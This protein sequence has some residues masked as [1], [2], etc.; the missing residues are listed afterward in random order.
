[1]TNYPIYTLESAPEASHSAL[2]QLNAE[3]G[4]LP[5]LAAC[6]ADSP[7]MISGFTALR[8]AYALSTLSPLERE[9][10]LLAAAQ[11]YANVYGVAVHSTMASRMGASSEVVEAVRSGVSVPDARVDALVRLAKSGARGVPPS[12]NDLEI[13]STLGVRNREVLDI[14][15]GTVIGKLA[16]A[17][18]TLAPDTPLD[19]PFQAH[20]WREPVTAD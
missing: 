5:N 16:A 10:V 14:M 6:M 9:L 4:F 2:Q 19:P 20:A 12:I 18:F 17:M 13:A 11:A 3:V 15:T 1:M 7:A 8:S